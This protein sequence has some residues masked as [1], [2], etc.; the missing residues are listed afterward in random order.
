M[1]F[2]C[3][4]QKFLFFPKAI[5]NFCGVFLGNKIYVFIHVIKIVTVTVTFHLRFVSSSETV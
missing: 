4:V 2:V 3:L 5:G 1:L